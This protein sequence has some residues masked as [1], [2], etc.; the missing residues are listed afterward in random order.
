M[1]NIAINKSHSIQINE[2]EKGRKYATIL[3]NGSRGGY[4]DTIFSKEAT[5]AQIKQWALDRI[6]A[7]HNAKLLIS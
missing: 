5:I 3:I 2:V 1:K 4:F 6:N 7:P